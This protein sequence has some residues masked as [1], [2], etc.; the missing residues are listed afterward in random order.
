MQK[1]VNQGFYDALKA[2]LEGK[3]PYGTNAK[4]GLQGG[5]VSYS[6]TDT[7]KA[8]FT[9]DQLAEIADVAAKI[10]DGTIDPGTAFG[11]ADGWFDEFVASVK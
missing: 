7:T 1:N 8:L 6:I 2:E 11:Q 5:Y 9:E 4:L 3:I 10:A